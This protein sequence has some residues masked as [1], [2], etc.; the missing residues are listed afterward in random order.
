[1]T[2][3]AR[4]AAALLAIVSLLFGQWAVASYACDEVA[5]AAALAKAPADGGAA[6]DDALCAE[7]CKPSKATA[8]PAAH[9]PVPVVAPLPQPLRVA[10]ME[11]LEAARAG[12]AAAQPQP[13]R[14]PPR[15]RFTVLRL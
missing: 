1:M 8:D 15:L 12:L 11:S 9:V 13:A 4:I 14:P 6:M 3:I 2:R 7:H 10:S 5:M